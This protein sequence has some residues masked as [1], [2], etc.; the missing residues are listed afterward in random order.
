MRIS[1]TPASAP[2]PDESAAIAAVPSENFTKSRRFIVISSARRPSP[3]VLRNLDRLRDQS[4]ASE[5]IGHRLL[6][7]DDLVVDRDNVII[8][9]VD[10]ALD[11]G[12]VDTRRLGLR[13]GDLVVML[14]GPHTF[15]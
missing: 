11:R 1:F 2:A 5:A 4:K 3:D 10:E 9:S 15:R 6:A 7:P 14:I 13:L 12:D 8:R